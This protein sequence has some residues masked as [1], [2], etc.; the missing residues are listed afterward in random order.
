MDEAIRRIGFVGTGIMG[1]HMARRLAEAGFEVAAWNRSQDKARAL[2]R[3]GIRQADISKNAAL[4]ADVLV[5]MLSSGPVCD[6]VLFG[7]KGAATVMKPGAIL[8][9][10]SSI[11]PDTARE[12]GRKAESLGLRYVDAPVSGGETGAREGTLAIMAGGRE[13]V[14]SR[15]SGVF[16][17]LGRPTH[18][19]PVGAGSLT[20]LANQLIVAT[21]IGTVAE[22]F[23]LAESGGADPAR[24]REALL[25]GFADS[26]VL[27][28]HGLRMV[29]GDFRPGGPAKYQIKDTG[30]ALDVARANKLDLPLARAIDALFRSM[31]DRGGGDLDH[32]A[33]IDEIKRANGLGETTQQA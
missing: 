7:S 17:A 25:G 21:T 29:T 32:S 16:G 15:L 22:A 31:V 4:N 14:V 19:G 12:Q 28:Q 20:K 8:L 26:T 2:V 5:C 24:V 6:E 10:M 33:L 3:F 13:D 23:V 9:V 30:A 27:R 18:V 1:G 11:A